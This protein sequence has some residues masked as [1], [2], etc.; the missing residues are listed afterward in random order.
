MLPNSTFKEER[1][2]KRIS[3]VAPTPVTS[4]TSVALLQ[5]NHRGTVL[6]VFILVVKLLCETLHSSYVRQ[7][8]ITLRLQ[9]CH[10][11]STSSVTLWGNRFEKLKE[12]VSSAMDAST[13]SSA[14]GLDVPLP[15]FKWHQ[16]HPDI[17]RRDKKLKE[18]KK[19]KAEAE[20]R[21]TP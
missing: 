5:S 10:L 4:V 20:K 3:K 11:G 17:K 12:H 19:K 14:T 7:G 21:K 13:V 15:V 2:A 18:K 1:S 16:M 8:Q 6:F 9:E